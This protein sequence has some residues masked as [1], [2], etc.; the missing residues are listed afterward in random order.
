MVAKILAT[1]AQW[2][3]VEC[4]WQAVTWLGGEAYNQ[5]RGK[6]VKKASKYSLVGLL[7]FFGIKNINESTL[8]VFMI[9]LSIMMLLCMIYY[10]IKKL[11]KK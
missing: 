5:V 4:A 8:N 7:S 9:S 6:T 11:T 1:I 3:A 10:L 2:V